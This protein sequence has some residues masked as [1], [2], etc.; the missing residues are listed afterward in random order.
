MTS[1]LSPSQIRRLRTRNQLLADDCAA[2]SA[3]AVARHLIAIQAQEWDSAQIAIAARTHDITA[4]DIQREREIDRGFVLTWAL[5]GTLHLVAA[6][7]L[8][9]MLRLCG[10]RVIRGTKRRYQQLGLTE[11]IRETALAHIDDILSQHGA[12]TR[13]E[14]AREL[15]ARG[16]PVAGQAIHHLARFAALRGLVCCGPERD[17]KLTF[18]LLR[19]W[20]PLSGLDDSDPLPQLARRYL[21]AYGPAS[22]ADLARWAGISPTQAKN[23]FAA[24]ADDTV[25]A[26]T[27]IGELTMLRDA[28]DAAERIPSAPTARLLPRYDNYALAYATR[29]VMV[30]GEYLK[31]VHPGGGLIRACV[32][33]DGKARANWR[34]D[35]RRGR[36]PH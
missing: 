14:L 31:R 22:Q 12:L 9:W 24:I 26:T 19:D 13:A 5:R 17:G 25:P 7:D 29:E 1:A 3:T 32:S 35:K 23:A 2:A 20:L 18:V 21:R 8:G 10:E 27:K 15:E 16:I 28:S 30:D 4:A 33:V 6:D 36:H 11:A 34:L